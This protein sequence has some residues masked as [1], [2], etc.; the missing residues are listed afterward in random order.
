MI[1]LDRRIRRARE[2][3]EEGKRQMQMYWLAR[4]SFGQGCDPAR[5]EDWGT[6]LGYLATCLHRGEAPAWDTRFEFPSGNIGTPRS[7]VDVYHDGWELIADVLPEME[8]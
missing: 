2:A 7:L 6:L 5:A 4:Y 3:F 8:N 1:K